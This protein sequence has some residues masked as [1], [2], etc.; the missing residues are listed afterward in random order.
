MIIAIDGLAGSGKSSTAKRLSNKI[1]FSYFSTGKMYRA[2]TCYSI[3]NDL[4]SSLPDSLINCIDKLDINFEK[5]NLNKILINKKDYSQSIYS[6]EVNKYV[7]AI[8]SI[9]RVRNIMVDLQRIAGK[10]NNLICEGRDIGT[11]VFPNAQLKFYFDADEEVRIKRR[12]KELGDKN[13]G[14]NLENVSIQLKNRDDRDRTR[15]NS[16]LK[17]AENAILVD[18]TDKS[19]DEVFQF[20]FDK[21]EKHLISR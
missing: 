20:V 14:S 7:S 2:I 9:E 21:V 18:T 4:I 6:K 10:N 3:E 12:L 11:V 15:A 8:S 1:G 5:N 19:L 16:P 17:R 13:L